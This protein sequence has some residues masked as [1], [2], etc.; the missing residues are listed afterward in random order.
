MKTPLNPYR[1]HDTSVEARRARYTEFLEL[2]YLKLLTRSQAKRINRLK[3][4]ARRDKE[5][6]QKKP[7]LIIA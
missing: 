2:K 6:T 4:I 3:R 1:D 5:I 7:E